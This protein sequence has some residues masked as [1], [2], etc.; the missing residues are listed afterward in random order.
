MNSQD[1]IVGGGGIASLMEGVNGKP[2]G[3]L[4]FVQKSEPA[5][6]F[7]EG[8]LAWLDGF[9]TDLSGIFGYDPYQEFYAPVDYSAAP[10][11]APAP[12]QQF[13]PYEAF[14]EQAAPD[15]QQ[16]FDFVASPASA[17]APAQQLED[18]FAY[19]PTQVS[20]PPP[21][22]P[23][24][25]VAPTPAPS[26]YGVS[27]DQQV[28]DFNPFVAAPVAA[29][30]PAPVAVATAPAP[31]EPQGQ[32][33]TIG[34]GEDRQE[35]FVPAAAPAPAS[36][37]L[38][39]NIAAAQSPFDW[40]KYGFTG[41]AGVYRTTE[42][43]EGKAAETYLAG[44]SKE[45]DDWL[46]QQGYQTKY[47][48]SG[49]TGE[50]IRTD[51]L[52][53]KNGNIIDTKQSQVDLGNTGGLWKALDTLQAV[54]PSLI[55]TAAGLP[56]WLASAGS[57]VFQSI[58]TGNLDLEKLATNAALSMVGQ[59]VSDVLPQTGNP[60][61]DKIVAAEATGAAKSAIT[62]QEFDPL[63]TL[64]SAAVS[65]AI[66]A[67]M[68]STPMPGTGGDLNIVPGLLEAAAGTEAQ[69]PEAQAPA[70]EPA[71]A[72]TP[73]PA[74]AVTAEDI[75]AL[76]PDAPPEVIQAV[77]DNLPAAP[78]VVAASTPE[79]PLQP[80]LLLLSLLLH[81]RQNRQWRMCLRLL[82]RLS[83]RKT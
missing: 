1:R 47:A 10:A 52:L 74:P 30:A 33:T 50:Q 51:Y 34:S 29:S 5:M 44:S 60:I 15:I 46:A 83:R 69:T 39:S 80:N 71:P 16:L 25:Y 79:P 75:Q 40:S 21:P 56:P 68:P 66:G 49:K 62:G 42:G 8:G 67:L 77:L 41:N 43:E 13:N 4:D 7:D 76:L 32:W 64:K 54:A 6:K 38:G 2:F 20:A 35:V 63:E 45:F 70:P 58:P 14:T 26:P 28:E 53:D 11:P 31:A 19:Q 57:T 72:P 55:L 81:R 37:Y 59:G 3:M 36:D 61:L 9:D 65:Q 48:L 12:V 78:E 18:L 73:A 17:P 23:A 24:P 27:F 82:S 22:A